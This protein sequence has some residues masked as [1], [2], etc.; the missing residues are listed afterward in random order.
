MRDA[1]SATSLQAEL[2]ND[3]PVQSP[4]GGVRPN[5]SQPTVPATQFPQPKVIQPVQKSDD[6]AVH[7]K[8][9]DVTTSVKKAQLKQTHHGSPPIVATVIACLVALVLSIGA[10]L[11]FKQ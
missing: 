3:I 11:V 10:V 9:K 2:V 5:T 8:P 7:G 4:A 6:Q 1:T